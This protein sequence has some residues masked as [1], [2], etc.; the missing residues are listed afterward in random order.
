M[1]EEVK[2][3]K[4]NLKENFTNKNFQLSSKIGEGRY[5]EVYACQDCKTND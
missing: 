1:M 4:N 2:P 5:S 3:R